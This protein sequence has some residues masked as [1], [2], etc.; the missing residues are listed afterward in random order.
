VGLVTEK[1]TNAEKWLSDVWDGRFNWDEG[2][3][4]KLSKHTL[5]PQ[6]V[7]SIFSLPVVFGGK[8]M[9]TKDQN[10]SEDR[11]V[12]YGETFSGRAVTL[13]WTMRNTK[14]R[15]ISCRSMRREE[16]RAFLSRIRGK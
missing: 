5:T 7:E 8:V 9:P 2:N 11:F 3:K 10:W 13:I 6:E 12:M 16:K 14:L 1:D 15:P 4:E